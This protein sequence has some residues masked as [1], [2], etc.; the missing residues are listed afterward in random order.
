MIIKELYAKGLCDLG[1]FYDRTKHPEAAII[2]YQS[3]IEEFP[4]TH[5]AEYC[6][7]RILILRKE[8]E[9]K[10]CIEQN[11]AGDEE[12]SDREDSN[13]YSFTGRRKYLFFRDIMPF[14]KYAGP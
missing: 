14:S 13:R 11:L 4:D 9:M 5:V 12:C 1:L 2:Y 7:S 8:M 10:A 6:K 3:S